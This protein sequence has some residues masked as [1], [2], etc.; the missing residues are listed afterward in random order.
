MHDS[1]FLIERIL[2]NFK[3]QNTKLVAFSLEGGQVSC[4]DQPW[5][6]YKAK[7][8]LELLIFLPPFPRHHDC[9]CAPPCLVEVVLWMGPRTSLVLGKPSADWAASPSP[10]QSSFWAAIDSRQRVVLLTSEAEYMPVFSLRFFFFNFVLSP[11]YQRMLAPNQVHK[12]NLE[13]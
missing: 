12:Q 1:C 13:L 8:D 9:T 10:N 6:C 7:S 11:S 2:I 3:Y 5:P 4:I